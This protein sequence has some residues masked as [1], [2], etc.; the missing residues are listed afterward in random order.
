MSHNKF[1]RKE[2]KKKKKRK[3][4]FLAVY[5]GV[6]V[7]LKDRSRKALA[8]QPLQSPRSWLITQSTGIALTKTMASRFTVI[9]MLSGTD[10][11]SPGQIGP[12][13]QK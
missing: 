5:S 1:G 7:I 2:E 9:A 13:K 11:L 6:A 4:H 3:S 12:T 10:E 8:I